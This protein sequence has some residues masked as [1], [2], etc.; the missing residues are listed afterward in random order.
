MDFTEWINQKFLEWR[1]DSR[2]TLTG[3]AK[4]IGVSQQVMSAWMS[5]NGNVPSTQ[6]AITKLVNR[7]GSEVY[8]ILELPVPPVDSPLDT[9]PPRLKEL[10]NSSLIEINFIYARSKVSP[11]SPEAV[12]IAEKVLSKYGFTINSV[13]QVDEE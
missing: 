13:E 1:G 12:S 9:L 10:L 3:F 8:K 7:Y 4:F 2:N 5:K 11:D 6:K